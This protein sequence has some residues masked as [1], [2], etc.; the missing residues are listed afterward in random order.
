M[1]HKI[2][3][4]LVSGILIFANAKSQCNAD[5]QEAFDPIC[6]NQP[7]IF[8]DL[9]TG[10]SPPFTWNWNFGAGATPATFVGQTPPTVI[11]STPG[12]KNITLTYTSNGGGCVDVRTRQIDVLPQP[13]VSFTSN[14]P[15][16]VGALVNFTYTGSATISYQWDFGVG[17]TPQASAVQNPQGII[18]SSPGIKTITLTIDNGVCTRTITQN[19]TINATPASTFSST[20]PQ[21]TGL[22]VDFTNT[23]TITGVSWLWN[24]GSGATPATS[25]AQNP[26]GIIYSSAG[27]KIVTLTTTDN[28]TGC[29]STTTQTININ[30]TPTASF[31]SNAPQC[32]GSTLNF[33]NT[34]STGG[35][36]SYFWDF[37]MDAIPQN[38]SAENPTGVSYTTGG[39]KTITFTVSDGNCTQ[40][41]TQTITI[42]AL[43]VAM[44]GLDTTI[45]ANTSVQIGSSPVGGNTYNWFP[46]N[47]LS[48]STIA[49]P[50]ASPIA[51]VTT[52]IV[53]VTNT[54]TGC[55][56][57]DSVN[58]T[59]LS[60]LIA[61]AGVD[62]EI[63]RFDSIQ[64]GT[65]LIQGQTYAWSPS[66]GLNSITSPNPVSSPSVTTTYTLTVTGSGCA[67]VSDEVTVIVH[68]LPIVSA[69]PDDTITTGQSTQL[70]ATGGVQYTWNPSYGLNNTGVFNPVANP[71]T[72]TTYIVTVIDIYGCINSDTMTVRVIAP[73]FWIATAFTPDNNGHN[74]VLYV[75][76]EGI[77]NFEFA[78]FDRWGEQL[79]YTK[80]LKTGWDGTKQ[81]TGQTMPQGAY[82]YFVKGELST[83]DPVTAK[84]MVNLIR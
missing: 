78:I 32:V 33:T 64:I 66:T 75:R 58:V 51:P 26:T 44:A 16:C 29:A 53:T 83:G 82:V 49:N 19:I 23:G 71:D 27:T 11:Y 15:Q 6:V 43:P 24:F 46:S 62:G 12:T 45:C 84:G 74:D 2:F 39:T 1:K 5:F 31:T 37:G 63:C 59:M 8:Y 4:S 60:P 76:G 10:G 22:P 56:N 77:N 42:N 40:T 52:Y 36:W 48:S 25:T 50:V 68:P 70:I 67:P 79:F 20:A 35:S 14:A 3:F 9:S 7:E 30:Q 13:A 72:T 69:G 28:G 41:S 34:G 55:I 81:G 61:D 47:T 73:S 17:A 18:Y 54:A 80:D 38:S 65:G 21:C 57:T